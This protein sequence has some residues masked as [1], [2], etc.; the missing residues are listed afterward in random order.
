MSDSDNED[1]KSIV[2]KITSTRQQLDEPT[3]IIPG[4]VD[5]VP[6]TLPPKTQDSDGS[7]DIIEEIATKI[8]DSHNILV[9]LSS[10]PSVD[11]LA[12]A[13]GISLS[14]DRMEKRATAIYSGTTPNALKFLNPEETL[15]AKPE[16]LQDFVIALNKEKA[17]HLR[18]KIDGDYVKI[19]ITPY[20]TQISQDDLEFSYGDFN[21]DLVLAL[22]V[23]NGIDLDDALR[24]HGRIM[25]DAT[26]INITTGKP[27]K[28][29]EIEWSNRQA[30]SVSEMVADLL[31]SMGKL[32]AEESTAFLTGIVAAT[33]RFANAH[34]TAN[35]LELASRLID[36]GANQQLIAKNITSN[37]EK[38]VKEDKEERVKPSP[39]KEEESTEEEKGIKKSE[40]PAEK[41]VEVK[42]K[43]HS[44]LSIHHD[45]EETKEEKTEEKEKTDEAS[46]PENSKDLDTVGPF[47]K[48]DDNSI[49]A[50]SVNGPFSKD[51]D[52]LSPDSVNGPFSK[53][54]DSTISSDEINGPFTQDDKPESSHNLEDSPGP[55]EGDSGLLDDLK[56]TE[57]SLSG[58]GAEVTPD[59]T[60]K[61]INMNNGFSP[62]PAD[63]TETTIT[64]PSDFATD[65]LT[66]GTN[67]YGQMLEDALAGKNTNLGMGGPSFSSPSDS[68]SFANP[69]TSFAPPVASS[70]E[71]NGVPDINYM[72][73]PGDEILPPPPTPPVDF[74]SPAP[75]FSSMPSASPTPVT[76][77]LGNQPAMQDQVYRP[78]VSNPGA[79]NIPGA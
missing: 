48:D 19:F 26:V 37:N 4:D 41:P 76:P 39:S 29:G 57:A 68:Q 22:N 40:E 25:H 43:D 1:T 5:D 16:I 65:N 18:Y 58:A 60:N 23:A 9:A 34:T 62:S 53:E 77:E 63:K 38:D 71:I 55:S 47:S 11:E 59:D 79:F 56:A 74:N 78:P 6:D 21:V 8:K 50:D 17:D 36:L 12:A 42:P 33:D 7:S 24:E 44:T 67:K 51:E 54:S 15:E 2:D 3:P 45:D 61:P 10:D 52:S 72:P 70:P 27:G 69:A 75:N 64:P 30:S 35:S 73:L 32:E 14:L 46:S 66:E 31:L 20:H 13:I 49:N 28:L